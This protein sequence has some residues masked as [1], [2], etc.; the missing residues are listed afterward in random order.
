MRSLPG[1]E[2]SDE[3]SE[4]A[5]S[6]W[7][8]G[9]GSRPAAGA[10]ARGATRRRCRNRSSVPHQP[11]L[12]AEPPAERERPRLLGE[13]R[14]G[15]AL[16]EEAVARARS[17]MV[18]P[19]RSR[20]SSSVS[21]SGRPALARQLHRPVGGREPGDA[22]R[23]RRRASRRRRRRRDEVGQHRDERGVVVGGGARGASR[24]RRTRRRP[25]APRRRGRR[26]PRRGRRR[27]RSGTTTTSRAP[28]ARQRADD[29]GD[30]GLEPRIAR[31]SRCG[32]G[33]RR[34]QR[35]WPSASATAR[36]AAV[37]L[38][39]RRARPRAIATGTLWAVKT[40]GVARRA[41]RGH[42][43]PAPARRA[44][45]IAATKRGCS[46]HGGAKTTSGAPGAD[47]RARAATSAT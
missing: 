45:A 30:V 36:A 39:R 5:A 20:A 9:A 7:A 22:R 42:L 10:A 11:V 35:A 15:P 16:D 6:A 32:S 33:R 8:P 41:R 40:S 27:S 13:E 24:S 14:V 3:V 21:S 1:H 29:V 25:P 18:P 44:S 4:R 34:D 28:S 38:G 37:E 46:N 43:A 17:A 23:R 2:K 12:D 47:A 31:A 19:R 26:A